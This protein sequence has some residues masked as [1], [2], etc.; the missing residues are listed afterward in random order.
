MRKFDDLKV[1]SKS[2][3]KF[4]VGAEGNISKKENNLIYV[5]SSGSTLKNLKKRDIVCYDFSKNQKNN[6][7]RKGTMELDFHIFL[8]KKENVNYVAHS[9]PVNTLKI[10]CSKYAE[11]FS[12]KRLFPDQVVFNGKKSCLVPYVMPGEELGVVIEECVNNFELN[13]KSFPKLILLKN[14]GIIACGKSV[15]ECITITEICEKAAEIFLGGISIKSINY[16]TSD[17]VECI[18]NDKNEN[19]RKSLI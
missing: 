8:L 19:Y 15:D 7:S 2:I 4:V 10:L 16:L 11:E 9:H 13:E 6:F 17:E 3:S 12:K 5:K 14:H 1:L 18:L